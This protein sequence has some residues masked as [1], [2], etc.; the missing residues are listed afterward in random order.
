[1]L[2]RTRVVEPLKKEAVLTL[3]EKMALIEAKVA[4]AEAT[5]KSLA[6]FVQ[7]KAKSAERSLYTKRR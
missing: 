7:A 1:M 4:R 5:A 3:E 2:T 6:E